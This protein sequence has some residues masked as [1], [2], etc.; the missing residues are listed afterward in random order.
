MTPSTAG[1][2]PPRARPARRTRRSSGRQRCP[3]SGT[4]PARAGRTSPTR[5]ARIP[6]SPAGPTPR[7]RAIPASRGSYIRWRTRRRRQPRRAL[8]RPVRHPRCGYRGQFVAH[9]LS[10]GLP[11]RDPG[12]P[13]SPC[14]GRGHAAAPSLTRR[15]GR[16]QHADS[17]LHAVVETQLLGAP[18]ALAN[19][20]TSLLPV[21]GPG[22]VIIDDADRRAGSV[23]AQAALSLI[24]AGNETTS[25]TS[26]GLGA[27]AVAAS[28][29]AIRSMAARTI[30]VRQPD[31]LPQP[32]WST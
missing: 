13:A 28:P 16:L 21:T 23:R 15:S 11:R 27:P 29:R 6:G 8:G 3:G 5:P 9:P 26:G 14:L 10:L 2:P 24:T 25:S 1:R 32:S 4:W 20:L 30:H 19:R 12:A 7:H 17:H 18:A 22:S 31:A